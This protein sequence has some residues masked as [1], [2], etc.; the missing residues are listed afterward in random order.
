MK[1]KLIIEGKEFLIEIHDQEL[2]KI[3][4]SQKKTGY[5][6]VGAGQTYWMQDMDDSACW[7]TEQI[8]Y[9]KNNEDYNCANYYSSE[10]IAKNNARADKLLRQLRRFAIE[11]RKYDLDWSNLVCQKFSIYHDYTKQKLEI[12]CNHRD[13]HLFNIYFDSDVVANAAIETFHDEL[14]WYFTEYKDS[15]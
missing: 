12:A 9:D 13:R 14:I 3:L 10:I 7:T 15:L 5:E 8:R 6:R 4:T 1:A 11:H 2:Q